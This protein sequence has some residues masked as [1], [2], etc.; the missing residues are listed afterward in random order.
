MEDCIFCKIVKGEIPSVRVW[1]NEEFLAILD[2]AQAVKGMT[3]LLSKEHHSSDVFTMPDDVFQ[4]F[5]LAG[6]ET[7]MVLKKGLGAKRVFMVIEG[8]DVDHAH[9]KLYPLEKVEPLGV[10]LDKAHSLPKKELSEL[11]EI[12]REIKDGLARE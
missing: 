10:I 11:Q 7:A 9:L 5:L 3:V 8:L 4:R 12:A 2:I 6:K 1:E